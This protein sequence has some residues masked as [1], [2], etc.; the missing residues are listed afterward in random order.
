MSNLSLQNITVGAL[1]RQIKKGYRYSVKLTEL[2]PFVDALMKTPHDHELFCQRATY[3]LEVDLKI[4]DRRSVVLMLRDPI[5]VEGKKIKALRLKGVFPQRGK[6][7]TVKSYS[8]GSGVVDRAYL[9]EEKAQIKTGPYTPGAMGTMTAGYLTK[10]VE[11]AQ[12]LDG[13]TDLL[14]GY[15]IYENF[16]YLGKPVGFVVYGM[17]RVVDSRMASYS[18]PTEIL[19]LLNK[20]GQALRACHE[21]GVIH[22]FPHL[23]NVALDPGQKVRL[24]DL[25]TA[26]LLPYIPSHLW[27]SNMYFDLARTTWDIFSMSNNPETSTS[28]FFSG[29]FYGQVPTNFDPSGIISPLASLKVSSLNTSVSL[30]G[31]PLYHSL[32]EVANNLTEMKWCDSFPG[33]LNDPPSISSQGSFFQ[34]SSSTR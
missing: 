3:S 12:K 4:K 23:G 16:T 10:E 26:S 33:N 14:L 9:F 2:K 5:D 7:H 8:D 1:T 18:S 24:V 21:A 25:E 29:Y 13:Q 22:G 28:A 19:A 30:A 31:Q 17:E 34:S 6:R 11:A 20:T 27:P 32:A 15:G